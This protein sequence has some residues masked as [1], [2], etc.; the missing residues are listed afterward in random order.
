MTRQPRADRFG[1]SSKVSTMLQ[2]ISLFQPV[3]STTCS[4]GV[5]I[6][7][8]RANV[9]NTI[10]QPN[11]FGKANQGLT[12]PMDGLVKP[13]HLSCW[14]NVT[15]TVNLCLSVHQ[16]VSSSAVCLPPLQSVPAT[17]ENLDRV[18]PTT[19]HTSSVK[20]LTVSSEE[21]CS[22]P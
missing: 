10:Q 6:R 1:N 17:A 21:L 8:D 13:G 4:V 9:V 14:E 11:S 15:A 3:L 16:S 18:L 20:S 5:N 19:T 2:T 7:K 12:N 22:C